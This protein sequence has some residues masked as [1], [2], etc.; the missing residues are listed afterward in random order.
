[1]IHYQPKP[2]LIFIINFDLQHQFTG[3]WRIIPVSKWLI[4]MVIVI[5]LPAV[6]LLRNG[7]SWLINGGD[8]NYL[9]TGMILQVGGCA[10]KPRDTLPE[11]NI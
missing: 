11:N 10:K 6:L 2:V 7:H 1:M 9:L 3:A 4:I 5:P 8:P